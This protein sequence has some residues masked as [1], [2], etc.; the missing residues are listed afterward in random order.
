[1][2]FF[3]DS[4]YKNCRE[5]WELLSGYLSGHDLWSIGIWTVEVIL[6]R[7]LKEM[8]KYQKL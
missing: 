5:S 3:E 2:V 8:R 6:R 7:S 4:E 1:M